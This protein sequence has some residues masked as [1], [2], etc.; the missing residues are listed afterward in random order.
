MSTLLLRLVG[1]MQAWDVQSHFTFRMTGLEPSKSGVVGLLCAALGKPR[2]EAP[3][4]GYP[5]IKELAAL[6]MGMRVDRE[7]RVR[8]DFHTA[9]I[10]KN[11][12]GGYLK[13]DGKVATENP[14]VSYR[15]YLHDAAFLV[16]FEG[17]YDLLERLHKALANPHWMLCLGRK[18]CVPSEP[19]YLPN[20]LV[21]S[22]NLETALAGHGRLRHKRHSDDPDVMRG[23]LEDD[24]GEI[25]RPDQPVSFI[26]GA[27]QFGLRRMKPTMFANQSL[28]KEIA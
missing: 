11:G 2:D 19:V 27:R 21:E 5:S 24:M 22:A 23:L 9:G 10:A 8:R 25:V 4:D 18:A 13:A 3:G 17:N 1:P 6:K 20:G 28:Y 7:G 16:G 15:W 26:K 12:I 14:V